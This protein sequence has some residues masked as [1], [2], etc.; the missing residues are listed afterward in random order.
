MVADNADVASLATMGRHGCSTHPAIQSEL[1]IA[2]G[3]NRMY[4][5]RG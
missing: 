3:S 1:L 2:T 4:A 5:T